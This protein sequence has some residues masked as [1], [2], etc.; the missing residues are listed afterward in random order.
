MTLL[1]FVN[2]GEEDG[3][4]GKDDVDNDDDDN[5]DGDFNGLHLR[6]SLP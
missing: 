2:D 6:Q 5:D 1:F 3:G 4:D